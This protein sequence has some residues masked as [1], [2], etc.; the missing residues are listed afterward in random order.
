MLAGKLNES[1]EDQPEKEEDE[2]EEKQVQNEKNLVSLNGKR[3]ANKILEQNDVEEDDDDELFKIK[4]TNDQIDFDSIKTEL[5]V[6]KRQ[7][8]KV[9]VEGHFEGRNKIYY[10]DEGKFLKDYYFKI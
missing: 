10:D 3:A 7:L 4:R 5:K 2:E 9:K 1:D 6:S 8:K